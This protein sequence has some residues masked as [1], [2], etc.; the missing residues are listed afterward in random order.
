MG[1]WKEAVQKQGKPNSA[2]TRGVWEG[3]G[4]CARQREERASRTRV[5]LRTEGSSE[6]LTEVSG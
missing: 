3:D 6:R 1:R 4:E 5:E 2:G